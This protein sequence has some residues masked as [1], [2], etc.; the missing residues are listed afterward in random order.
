MPGSGSCVS[1][2]L[3]ELN[4]KRVELLQ[5]L[6][7]DAKVFGL[8]LNPRNPDAERQSLE[9]QKAASTMGRNLVVATASSDGELSPAFAMLA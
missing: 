1:A 8:L 3:N 6:V 7:P 5:Q 2:F 4:P 9:T